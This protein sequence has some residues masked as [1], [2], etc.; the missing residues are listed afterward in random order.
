MDLD[1]KKN[2]VSFALSKRKTQ[3]KKE[4]SII[5]G[6][7]RRALAGQNNVLSYSPLI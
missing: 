2:P 5:P 7:Q 6:K 1:Q 4:Q 3:P